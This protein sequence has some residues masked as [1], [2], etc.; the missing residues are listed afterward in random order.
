MT[1]IEKP[2]FYAGKGF[3][4]FMCAMG[5][6]VVDTRFAAAGPG[7]LRPSR[8]LSGRKY[9]RKPLRRPIPLHAARL[10][11]GMALHFGRVAGQ[12]AATQ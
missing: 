6:L 7:L 3:Y 9:Y 8:T 11:N 1:T 5:G 12:N 4:W 2:P 10:S